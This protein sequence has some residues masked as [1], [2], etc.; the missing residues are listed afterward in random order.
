MRR[1]LARL[2]ALAAALAAVLALGAA[3]L[4]SAGS[5]PGDFPGL[6]PG[7]VLNVF[8]R[9]ALLARISVSPNGQVGLEPGRDASA[10]AALRRALA[11]ARNRETLPLV[12]EQVR[13]MA[14]LAGRAVEMELAA[15]SDA[16]YAWALL[17][18]LRGAGFSAELSTR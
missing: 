12:G 13:P 3:V 6:G 2:G 18:F 17:D 11:R 14:G 8:A 16:R 9:G 4:G 5:R 15:P 7:P 10:L 1:K